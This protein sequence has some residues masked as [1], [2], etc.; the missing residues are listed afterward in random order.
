MMDD[1]LGSIRDNVIL[2]IPAVAVAER[3]FDLDRT[4]QEIRWE[5]DDSGT[6]ALEQFRAVIERHGYLVCFDLIPPDLIRFVCRA[7]DFRAGGT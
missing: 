2:Q 3:A 4:K 6:P 1:G 5:V 7:E